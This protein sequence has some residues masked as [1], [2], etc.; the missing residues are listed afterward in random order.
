MGCLTAFAH[1][2]TLRAGDFGL[3]DEAHSERLAVV[4]V[5]PFDI[6]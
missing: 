2:L 4:A 5:E 1:P 6:E 3:E